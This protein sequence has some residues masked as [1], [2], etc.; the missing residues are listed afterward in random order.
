MN[1][2]HNILIYYLLN[3]HIIIISV[4]INDFFFISNHLIT[5]NILKKCLSKN[6]IS[7]IREKYKLFFNNR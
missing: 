7:N 6:I 4:Y 1:E 5:S 2:D 3:R